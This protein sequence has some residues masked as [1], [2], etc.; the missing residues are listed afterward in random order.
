MLLV[1]IMLLLLLLLL[2][3]VPVSVPGGSSGSLLSAITL[4]RKRAVAPST[5]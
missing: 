5:S 3:P 4:T 1:I 2:A